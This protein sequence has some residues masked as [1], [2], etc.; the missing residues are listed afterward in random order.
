MIGR[1]SAL[2]EAASVLNAP[3]LVWRSGVGSLSAMG[4]DSV[5]SS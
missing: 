2:V 3:A 4:G 5:L 1:P